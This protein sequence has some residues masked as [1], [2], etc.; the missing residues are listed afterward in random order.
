MIKYLYSKCLISENYKK[1]VYD[2]HA[3]FYIPSHI[4]N[5][6][7]NMQ[8]LSKL[9]PSIV[10]NP[11]PEKWGGNIE[12]VMLHQ[13]QPKNIKQFGDDNV[14]L[15]GWDWEN[16]KFIHHGLAKNISPE[17]NEWILL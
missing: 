12:D 11:D 13:Q 10:Q 4:D 5:Q 3:L 8:V 6:P 9:C 14:D 1:Y 16:T 2:T 7:L 17:C 15:W